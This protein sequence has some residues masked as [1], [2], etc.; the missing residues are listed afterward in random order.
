MS[1]VIT[2]KYRVEMNCVS[3]VKQCRE[4]QSFA[5]QGKPSEKRLREFVDGLNASLNEGG[6][7]E[8]LRD[9]QS[10]Y[11]SARIVRQSDDTVM[12]S[13]SKP[14]FEIIP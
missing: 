1:R 12:V 10:D 7:N 8:H 5:W 13:Y 6:P 2:P 9:G 4:T 11:T 3:F 14:M